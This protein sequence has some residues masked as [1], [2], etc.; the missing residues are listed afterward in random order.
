MRRARGSFTPVFKAE[1]PEGICVIIAE[2]EYEGAR[3]TVRFSCRSLSEREFAAMVSGLPKDERRYNPN[4]KEWSVDV[5]HYDRLFDEAR[6]RFPVVRTRRK[7]EYKEF[8][9]P[10][11]A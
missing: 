9:Q 5:K 8:K 2:S 7:G 4:L 1:I 3:M 10:D 6:R 11:A